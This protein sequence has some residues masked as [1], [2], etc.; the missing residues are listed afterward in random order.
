VGR[1]IPGRVIEA[2]ERSAAIRVRF[3]RRTDRAALLKLGHPPGAEKILAPS[4]AG[5]LRWFLNGTLACGLVAEDA[6][7][8]TLVGSAHFVRSRR[9]AATWVFGLWRVAGARRREGIGGLLLREAARLVPGIRR[10]YSYVDW[11]NEASILAHRR[12]GFEAAPEVQGRAELGALSTIGPAA[13]AVRLET[14]GSGDTAALFDLYA[15]ALGP[16][17]LRLFP[18]HERGSGGG[19]WGTWWVRDG[20]RTAGFVRLRGRSIVLYTDP[21]ACDAGLLARAATQI[22]ALGIPRQR[23]IDLRGLPWDLA[24]RPGPIDPRILMGLPDVGRLS[25]RRQAPS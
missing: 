4:I 23:E 24:S 20:E 9:D 10:L 3:C 25:D 8:G 1:V 14:A 21:A 13:P 18:G 12:L 2:T 19:R 7:A 5:R 22:V 11:G 6:A 16:L 17:W 15:R